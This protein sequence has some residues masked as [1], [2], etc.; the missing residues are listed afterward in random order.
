L[1]DKGDDFTK[2]EPVGLYGEYAPIHLRLMAQ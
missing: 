2:V 1:S